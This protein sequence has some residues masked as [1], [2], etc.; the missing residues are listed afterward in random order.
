MV[1]LTQYNFTYK[2]WRN[3]PD[4]S[5]DKCIDKLATYECTD[6][7]PEEIEDLKVSEDYWHREALKWAARMGESKI[8]FRELLNQFGI[9]EDNFKDDELEKFLYANRQQDKEIADE[10]R[11]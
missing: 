6:L 11:N 10:K 3:M 2:E 9:P 4:I 8:K 7:E 1:R 5:I